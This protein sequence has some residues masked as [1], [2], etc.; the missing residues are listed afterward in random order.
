VAGIVVFALGCLMTYAIIMDFIA[1]ARE[2][3]G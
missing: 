1:H 2:R 3:S